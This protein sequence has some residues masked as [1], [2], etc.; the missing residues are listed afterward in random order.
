MPVS[1]PIWKGQLRLSLVSIA[2]ELFSATKPN[3]KP[4]FRQIHEPS[5]KPINYEKV[6]AGIGPVDKDEIMKGFEY[7]KGDYVLLTDDEIDAVKLETRKTLE[8]TQF[9][10]AHEIDPI[11]FDKPY[12]VVPADELAEDAFRVIRDA[13]RASKKVGLGQ[14]ALRGKEYLVAVQPTGTGL[15]METLHYEDEIRKADPFFSSISAKK[16]DEDLLEVATALIDKKTAK[17]DAGIFKDHYQAALRELIGRK[18]K[19]KGKRVSTKEEEPEE[20]PSGSNVVDLMAAL[21]SSLEGTG[22]PG[23]AATK[24]KASPRKKAV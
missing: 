7:E 18:L 10:D 8:L 1:R 16:A 17:F 21:K 5:G 20:R 6:V 3:A 12:F 24:P 14:L 4:S 22:A 15:L 9:V 2:V 13:L 23:K 19:S 11:Y